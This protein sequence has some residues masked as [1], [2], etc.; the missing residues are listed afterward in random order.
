MKSARELWDDFKVEADIVDT[1]A[2]LDVESQHMF[3]IAFWSGMAM[4]TRQLAR[5]APDRLPDALYRLNKEAGR[6]VNAVGRCVL[7]KLEEAE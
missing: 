6:L 1:L 2:G 4:V 3:A 7:E 5:E